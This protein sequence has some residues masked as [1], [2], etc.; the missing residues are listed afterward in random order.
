M[1]GVQVRGL[2]RIIHCRSWECMAS[3]TGPLPPEGTNPYPVTYSNVYCAIRIDVYLSV[4]ETCY[5]DA[6][7]CKMCSWIWINTL[8]DGVYVGHEVGNKHLNFMNVCIFYLKC[9][10][11]KYR[12]KYKSWKY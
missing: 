7:N 5:V 1:F 3:I 6:V 11:L 12:F 9:I 4:A 2:P 10:C 8:S